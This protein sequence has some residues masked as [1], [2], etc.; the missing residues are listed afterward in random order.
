MSVLQTILT[1]LQAEFADLTEVERIT[2]ATWRMGE[3]LL[4]GAAIG[5]DRERRDAE[6]GLRTHMLV[7]LGAALFVLI[8]LETGMDDDQLSRVVQ[9]LVSGIGFLGAGA[10][11]KDQEEGRIHGLTTAAGIW[12]TAAVGMAAG[13]GH[14]GIALLA[15]IFILVVLVWLRRI[16]RSIQREQESGPNSSRDR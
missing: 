11:L 14:T 13:M 8:C 2:R 1:T 5:W 7:S 9:G 6:A 12:A 16:G 4:L 15:T 3:A 10:V